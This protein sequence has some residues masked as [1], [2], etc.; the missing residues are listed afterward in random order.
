[1]IAEDQLTVIDG[2]SNKNIFYYYTITWMDILYSSL[3][4]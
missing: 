1:M 2:V 4:S 3:K